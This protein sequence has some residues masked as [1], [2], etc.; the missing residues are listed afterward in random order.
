MEFKVLVTNTVVLRVEAD[1]E[2]EAVDMAI[3]RASEHDGEW[4][5]D[6]LEGGDK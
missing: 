2:E 4:D 5:A 6:I 1:S 3:E